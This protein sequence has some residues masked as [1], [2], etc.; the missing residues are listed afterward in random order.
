MAWKSR[1]QS[2]LLLFWLAIAWS[3]EPSSSHLRQG[4]DPSVEEEF[5]PS[6][7]H[8][9]VN[10]QVADAGDYPWYAKFDGGTTLCGG[11]VIGGGQFVLTAAHCVDDGAPPRVRVGTPFFSQGGTVL[12]V[13]KRWIHPNY[14]R[15]GNGDDI[16]LLKLATNCVCL[17]PSA[18]LNT[19]QTFPVNSGQPLWV[20]GFGRTSNG[21]DASG[22]LQQLEV[23]SVSN[24]ECQARGGN[25]NSPA[26]VCADVGGGGPCQGDS[27]SPLM[28]G[29]K[30]QVGIVSFGKVGCASS[31]P[32]Y[33]TRVS[34]YQDWIDTTINNELNIF[35]P[36]TEPMLQ[37]LRNNGALWL[38]SSWSYLF[39]P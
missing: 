12:S 39:G 29:N 38:Q 19:D 26:I 4:F 16:A 28:D 5:P 20:I 25:F 3:E 31:F 17:P 36:D 33:Y 32:D 9:I 1:F 34:N 35:G 11:T 18:E 13:T 21:G 23:Q 6:N 8:G 2:C 30:V 22:V 10:G 37:F 24:A 14:V 27:G 7:T 15:P